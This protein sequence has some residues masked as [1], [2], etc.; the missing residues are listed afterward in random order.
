MKNK[1]VLVMLTACVCFAV[2]SSQVSAAHCDYTSLYSEIGES[3]HISPELLEALND[4][5]N[6]AI[7]RSVVNNVPDCADRMQQLGV[8]D[9]DDPSSSIEIEAS[10]LFDLF[11]DYEDIEPVVATYLGVAE[12]SSEVSKI[13]A[14]TYMLETE[15]GKHTYY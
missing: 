12:D 14:E 2:S 4:S 13:V 8:S 1:L 3:Y 10:Y 7:A 15:H 5:D 11:V 6:T 9:L